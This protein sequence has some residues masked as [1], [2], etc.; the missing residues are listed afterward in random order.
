MYEIDACFLMLSTLF[1]H[2]TLYI[3]IESGRRLQKI[4][5]EVGSALTINNDKN[6]TNNNNNNNNCNSSTPDLFTREN[7]VQRIKLN[8]LM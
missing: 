4:L 2:R 5:Q 6:I 8:E 7:I 3:I 1:F